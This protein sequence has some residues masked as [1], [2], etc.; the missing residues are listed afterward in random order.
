[1]NDDPFTCVVSGCVNTMHD[2]VTRP[3]GSMVVVVTLKSKTAAC[4]ANNG[5]NSKST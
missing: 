2:D 4:S 1:M 3:K 5:A